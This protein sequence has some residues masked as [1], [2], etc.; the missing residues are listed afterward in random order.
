MMNQGANCNRNLI[1][2]ISLIFLL[3]IIFAL[4]IYIFLALTFL[5]MPTVPLSSPFD[6]VDPLW[7]TLAKQ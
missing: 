7:K 3:T 1:F 2:T 4:A 5:L 6:D